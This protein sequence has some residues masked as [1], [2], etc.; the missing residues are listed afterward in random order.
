[1]YENENDRMNLLHKLWKLW[2]AK[3]KLAIPSFMVLIV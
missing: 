3:D 1:M 2:R